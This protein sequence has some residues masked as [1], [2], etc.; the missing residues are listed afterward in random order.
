[1][2]SS[3]AQD[4]QYII[5][6]QWNF[7][8]HN[9]GSN[10]HLGRP[11]PLPAGAGGPSPPDL[12]FFTVSST[13]RIKQA[14]SVAAV[15]ALIFTMAGSQTHASKLSA[16]S[17]LFISTPYH[18]PPKQRRKKIKVLCEQTR[19]LTHDFLDYV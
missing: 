3:A 2:S 6:N 14:A 10:S 7:L 4:V 8:S 17:S 11:R 1:M 13:D 16:M 19:E 15:M 18:M 9:H 12:G 5:T